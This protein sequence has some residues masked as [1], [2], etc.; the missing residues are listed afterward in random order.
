MK[1]GRQSPRLRRIFSLKQRRPTVRVLELLRVRREVPFRRPT[2]TTGQAITVNTGGSLGLLNDVRR[3]SIPLPGDPTLL[4]KG[5]MFGRRT[6]MK[7]LLQL[8]NLDWG[9]SKV[10]PGETWSSPCLLHPRQCLE[11]DTKRGKRGPARTAVPIDGTISCK[12]IN[13]R[14]DWHS[15]TARSEGYVLCAFT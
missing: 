2:L 10:L 13:D 9:N 15:G 1:L 8:N 3:A 6:E 7:C 4:L 5:N 12:A 14:N 11:S